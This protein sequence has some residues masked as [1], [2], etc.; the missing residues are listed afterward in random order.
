MARSEAGL[1][2]ALEI[3]PRL[4]EQFWQD[5]CVPEGGA[6]VNQALEKAGRIADFLELGELMCRDA[7]N[8]Q[9]SCGAHFRVEYQTTEGEGERD[10]VNYAY[11]AAWEY[12]GEGV[13]PVLHKET[14]KF[15]E[16]PPSTRSYK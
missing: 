2:H 9:E 10:D 15:Q 7:L 11:V 1:K 5:A 16:F 3:I 8:R 13:P 6:E 12:A 4:R 14:L